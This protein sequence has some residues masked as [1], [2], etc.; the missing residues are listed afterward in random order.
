MK[1]N[2]EPAMAARNRFAEDGTRIL[3]VVLND[4]NPKSSLESSY[5]YY[6]ASHDMSNFSAESNKRSND[7]ENRS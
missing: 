5:G 1:T 4:W 6:R 3:G 2:H 7:I